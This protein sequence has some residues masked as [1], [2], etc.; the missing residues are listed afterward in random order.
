MGTINDFQDMSAFLFGS[1]AAA[2]LLLMKVILFYVY[3]YCAN[4]VHINQ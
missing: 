1:N 2:V 3:C 4:G